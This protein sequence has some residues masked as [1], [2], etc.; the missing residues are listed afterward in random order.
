MSLPVIKTASQDNP[1]AFLKLGFI[2]T[3]ETLGAAPETIT[4]MAAH[5]DTQLVKRAERYETLRG[6]VAKAL[7]VELPAA[8]K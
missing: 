8:T 1:K 6:A 5:Y 4:K 7:G 3:L 2:K